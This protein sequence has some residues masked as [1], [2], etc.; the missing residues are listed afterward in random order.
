MCSEA[1]H[2]NFRWLAQGHSSHSLACVLC[3]LLTSEE[4]CGCS[5]YLVEQDLVVH[6]L[7]HLSLGPFLQQQEGTGAVQ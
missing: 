1:P 4:A 7:L 5:A 3:N 2:A 6:L